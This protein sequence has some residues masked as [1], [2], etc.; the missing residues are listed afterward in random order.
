M[1]N[2]SLPPLEQSLSL[3]L[4]TRA[5]SAEINKAER[6]T[7]FWRPFFSFNNV[8]FS[9]DMSRGDLLSV[10]TKYPRDIFEFKNK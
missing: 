3:S 8:L 2:S 7:Y 6:V 5:L 4:L 1:F 9:W 10:T